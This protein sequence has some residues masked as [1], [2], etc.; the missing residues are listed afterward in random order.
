MFTKFF[1]LPLVLLA[2]FANVANAAAKRGDIVYQSAFADAASLTDWQGIDGSAIHTVSM[3]DGGTA[4]HV[5]ATPA[6][7]HTVTA[8]LPIPIEK[9]RGIRVVVS[10]KVKAADIVKPEHAWNGVK[11][12]LH[13]TNAGGEQYDQGSSPDGTFDWREVRFG[14]EIA[15]NAVSAQLVLGIENTTGAADFE[16]IR[17][18]V[19]EAPRPPMA[20][21]SRG[22][23]YTGH[24]ATPLRGA[25]VADNIDE[26]GAAK[27]A[28]DW[29]ANVVRFQLVGSRAGGPTADY[30][31]AYNAWLES[32]LG[33]LDRFLPIAQ[34][35]GLKVV[36]DMHSAPGG[37]ISPWIGD[38]IFEDVRYQDKLAEAWDII[39]KRYRGNPAIWGYDL[40]NEPL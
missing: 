19:L 30:T 33:K 20:A 11:V 17:I 39:S 37:R 16:D 38:R 6:G 1:L 36:V 3:P 2:A 27:L 9:L 13:I 10:A 18:T 29:K 31:P 24:A 28:N 15:E 8:S 4:L 35:Y 12:M 22:S 23:V 34:K 14:S 26:T 5:E 21:P 32:E 7:S 25:M 40:C